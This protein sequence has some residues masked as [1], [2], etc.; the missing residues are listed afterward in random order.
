MI[1]KFFLLITGII[2]LLLAT[3]I[4]LEATTKNQ[5][6]IR[7]PNR[8]FI[9][10]PNKLYIRG[11]EGKTRFT[12]NSL[13]LRGDE[14]HHQEIR[15][16]ALGGSA[17]ECGYLDDSEAWPHLVQEHLAR[18]TGRSVWVGNAGYS[19][20]GT[21]HHILQ[22]TELLKQIQHIDLV[23]ILIGA[24]ETIAYFK[25]DYNPL[26]IDVPSLREHCLR[27]AFEVTPIKEG[28]G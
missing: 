28:G 15:I 23:I 20:H 1:E 25:P 9:L 21:R 2:I 3:E 5:F 22:I 11:I 14:L 19:A 10:E 4:F 27:D 24:N 7:Q 13:G 26:G 16:L 18:K 8:L 17:T 6:F 12:V